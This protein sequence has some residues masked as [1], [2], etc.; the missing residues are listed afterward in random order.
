MLLKLWLAPSQGACNRRTC[1]V[2]YQALVV[3]FVITAVSYALAIK[4][5]S[6][7]LP[8]AF[9]FFFFSF[10]W[11]AGKQLQKV[12]RV[13]SGFCGFY[14]CLSFCRLYSSLRSSHC[15][16]AVFREGSYCPPGMKTAVNSHNFC[17]WINCFI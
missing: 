8:A 7:M 10:P 3:E 5:Y 14:S 15:R 17:Y 6:H 11:E 13:T 2:L 1:F 9:F 4:M 12:W 16:W